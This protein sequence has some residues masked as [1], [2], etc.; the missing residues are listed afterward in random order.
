MPLQVPAVATIITITIITIIT[1]T[2]ATIITTIMMMMASSPHAPRTCCRAAEELGH[3]EDLP[4]AAPEN[5][6]GDTEFLKK[7]HHALLEVGG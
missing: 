4:K 3:L 6:E 5:Y 2:I 1:T 7:A